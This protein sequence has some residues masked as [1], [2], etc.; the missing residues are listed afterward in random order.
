[1]KKRPAKKHIVALKKKMNLRSGLVRLGIP[2]FIVAVLVASVAGVV[3]YSQQNQS[4]ATNW[5]Y[6]GYDTQF[7]LKLSGCKALLSTDVVSG[8]VYY[9]YQVRLMVQ[10]VKGGATTTGAPYALGLGDV[11]SSGYWTKYIS[12]QYTRTYNSSGYSYLFSSGIL[13]TIDS[14]ERFIISLNSTSAF[15]GGDS[16]GPFSASSVTRCY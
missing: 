8:H 15:K 5:T 9:S 4:H 7:G 2:L 14:H 10:H 11:S 1:V 16:Y 13:N 12:N 3:I 6:L